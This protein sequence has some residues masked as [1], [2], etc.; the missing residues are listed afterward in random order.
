MELLPKPTRIHIS[1]PFKDTLFIYLV[2][3]E[4]QMNG[5]EESGNP[6]VRQPVGSLSSGQRHEPQPT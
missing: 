5:F 4:F 3:Y 1:C 6:T 2:H